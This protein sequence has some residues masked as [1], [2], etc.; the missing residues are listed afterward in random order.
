MNKRISKHFG[1]FVAAVLGFVAGVYAQSNSASTLA[2]LSQE[3]AEIS[4]MDLVLLNTRVEVLQEMLKDELLVP[5]A[6]TSFSFD[7]Q[8]QKIRVSVHVD[9]AA[10][11]NMTAG[12]LAKVLE[13]RA[14]RLC[15]A[16]TQ[17]DGNLPYRPYLLGQ[18]QPPEE[19]CAIRFFTLRLDSSDHAQPTDVAV[20]EDGKLTMKWGIQG[21]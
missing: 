1:V 11:A 6:P 14:V 12:Q 20:Y 15:V 7:A 13:R 5:F 4:K 3:K 9:S 17:A 19:Y 10:L 8:R 21:F 16:P 18:S 2:R